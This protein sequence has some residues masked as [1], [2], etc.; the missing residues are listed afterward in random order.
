MHS[1]RRK[2]LI[3]W[4]TCP[5]DASGWFR[6]RSIL[7]IWKWYFASLGGCWLGFVEKPR[8]LWELN[9]N[10]LFFPFWPST[11]APLQCQKCSAKTS[12]SLSL[13][14][15][16]P[17]GIRAWTLS[18]LSSPVPL[19]AC[20]TRHAAWPHQSGTACCECQSTAT[21]RTP[22]KKLSPLKMHQ[23]KWTFALWG[24]P[25]SCSDYLDCPQPKAVLTIWTV[26]RCSCRWR[27]IWPSGL[28]SF[29]R[30]STHF[31]PEPGRDW[32]SGRR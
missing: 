12:P 18:A 13:V 15:T 32:P 26:W 19:S 7:G 22:C 25:R 21:K 27:R 11:V 10:G 31:I 8:I 28:G 5:V 1:T 16:P 4:R 23:W 24:F 9:G 20:S 29:S 3:K 2:G 6:S 30:R 14:Q 17:P